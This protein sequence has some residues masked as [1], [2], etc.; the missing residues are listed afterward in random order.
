MRRY[1]VA[2]A[3]LAASYVLPSSVRSDQF[4]ILHVEPLCHGITNQ[5]TLQE[6]LRTVTFNECMKAEQND[7]KTM[8]KEWSTFS[9][10]DKRHCRSNDGWRVKL[11][12]SDYLSGNGT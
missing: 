8:I 5:S 10:D 11:Y 1:L 2:T 9:A 4:P 6:G 7:Q 12:G 3:V